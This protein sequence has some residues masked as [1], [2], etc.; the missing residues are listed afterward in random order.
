VNLL[1]HGTPVPI[2][3]RQAILFSVEIGAV[4]KSLDV[5]SPWAKRFLSGVIREISCDADSL[6]IQP[7]FLISRE[8]SLKGDSSAMNSKKITRS[9]G[10]RRKVRHPLTRRGLDYHRDCFIMS[11]HWAFDVR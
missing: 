6:P 7:E 9:S 3:G 8:T 5:L 4:Q 1:R 11:G 10:L 2:H